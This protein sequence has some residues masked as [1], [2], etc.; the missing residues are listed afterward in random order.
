MA[1][2]KDGYLEFISNNGKLWIGSHWNPS[3]MSKK[4]RREVVK[5]LRVIADEIER[6]EFRIGNKTIKIHPKFPPKCRK[7]PVKKAK[8]VRATK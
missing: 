6:D 8:E 1:T 2:Y 4:R 5:S 3:L 7:A